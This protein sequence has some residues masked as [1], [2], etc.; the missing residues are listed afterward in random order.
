MTL[1]NEKTSRRRAFTLIELLVV[2]AIISVLVALLVPAVQQAREAARRAQCKNNLKQIGLALHNYHDAYTCLP[3][4]VCIRPGDFGQWSAQARLLPYLDQANLQNLINFSLPYAGQPDVPKTRIP[5]YLCPSEINDRASLRDGIDQYPLNYAANQG[6]WLVFD[7]IGGA[8]SLGAFMPNGRL[9][10]ADFADGM[11]NTLG[12]AEVKTF[13]PNVKGGSSP[14]PISP[15]D[16]AAVSALGAGSEFDPIDS[17]TEWVEGRVHQTG[18]TTT[19][20]PNSNVPYTFDSTTYDIDYTSA[21]EDVNVT[22]F[23]AITSRSYHPGIV[24]VLLMDGSVR[25][26]SSGIN[27]G[28]WRNLSTRAGGEVVAEY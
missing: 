3:P 27:S 16:P 22:T 28:T 17:H 10:A 7:P 19:L 9:R 14:P 21:E 6:T 25:S 5:V 23:A 20:P 1:M 26:I 4:T 8:K 15:T 2:I 18:F 24:Q 12:F 13:Q 11:S